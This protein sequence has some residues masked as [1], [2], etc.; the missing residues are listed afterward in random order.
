[1]F[2]LLFS[3]LFLACDK[4]KSV[5]AKF[6]GTFLQVLNKATEIVKIKYPEAMLW[7]GDA[8]VKDSA[9]TANDF[10]AW[11]FLYKVGDEKTAIVIYSNS[12]FKM[13]IEPYPVFE[14]IL[15]KEV[16][17]DLIEAI[18]L[19]RKADYNDVIAAANLRWPLYPGNEEP[20]YIFGCPKIG[21]VFVG[22]NS[23]SV[24]VMPFGPGTTKSK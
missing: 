4:P 20:Y 19:M 17:M 5:E 3:F 9:M 10:V 18:D 15:I 12:L 13:H 8:K 22:V 7:E 21:H 11:Q 23:K 16:K 2:A 14:D 24:T 1:V 6:G